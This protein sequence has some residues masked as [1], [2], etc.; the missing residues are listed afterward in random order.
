[1]G[2]LLLITKVPDMIKE[3]F[4]M[5]GP[6]FGAGIGEAFGPA[7]K[8]MGVGYKAGATKTVG[9]LE[10]REHFTGAGILSSIAGVRGPSRK[11]PSG[12][13]TSTGT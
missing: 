3:A 10:S 4:K 12:D 1:L 2:M 13:N 8:L 7:K 9:V 5:R 6:G 11:S